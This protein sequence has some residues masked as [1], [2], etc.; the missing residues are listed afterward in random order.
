[1]YWSLDLFLN[2]YG[3]I[4]LRE[5]PISKYKRLKKELVNEF[6]DRGWG[7]PDAIMWND[8]IRSEME[9]AISGLNEETKQLLRLN[10]I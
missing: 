9:E 7:I 4:M 5:D 6:D 3:D 1:M 10:H 8:M 2:I